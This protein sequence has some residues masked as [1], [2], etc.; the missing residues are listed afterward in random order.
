MLDAHSHTTPVPG[1]TSTYRVL[2]RPASSIAITPTPLT[3][4]EILPTT[5]SHPQARAIITNPL[6]THATKMNQ[7]QR[8]CQL[9]PQGLS[10]PRSMVSSSYS[11]HRFGHSDMTW[12]V[13]A[14]SRL[15]EIYMWNRWPFMSASNRET[16]SYATGCVSKALDEAPHW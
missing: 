3:G 13:F 4:L 16:V 6:R 15:L 8:Q 5:I 14:M 1:G 10:T 12:H 11:I 9:L 7:L 2:S